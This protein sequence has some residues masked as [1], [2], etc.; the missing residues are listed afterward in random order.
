[1]GRTSASRSSPESQ[2][3][4]DDPHFTQPHPTP[5][6]HTHTHPRPHSHPSAHA[7][8]FRD[9]NAFGSGDIISI[10]EIDGYD[11]IPQG[12][13]SSCSF[14]ETPVS[15]HCG[16]RDN[17]TSNL[18]KYFLPK[19]EQVDINWNMVGLSKFA[20]A[21]ENGT[22]NNYQFPF[23]LVL[24]PHPDLNKV[25]CSFADFTS[26]LKNIGLEWLGKP[27]YKVYAVHDPWYS[28]PKGAP[29]IRYLGELV[30][31]TTF[32]DSFFGDTALAFQHVF[33]KDEMDNL[34]IDESD[35]AAQWRKYVD[36]QNP[37]KFNKVEGAAWYQ[38]FLPA[39]NSSVCA[40]DLA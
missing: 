27:I 10:W 39:W 13:Q 7:Q 20:R 11:V 38:P 24:D 17:I 2:T 32:L 36:P 33:Q 34:G 22:L 14:F 8:C 31:D 25:P 6:I 18:R 21:A 9:Q 40:R 29:D 12:K 23:A 1:M 4:F 37:G 16:D 28:R 19:F 26:Q 35:R 5:L 15:N 3:P 30:L